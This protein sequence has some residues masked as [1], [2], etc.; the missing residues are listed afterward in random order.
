MKKKKKCH[1]CLAGGV[2]GAPLLRGPF[3]TITFKLR[4]KTQVCA[5]EGGKPKLVPQPGTI[6]LVNPK[7]YLF[8]ELIVNQLG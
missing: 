5:G 2:G 7:D 4:R 3:P 8:M 6:C 1:I